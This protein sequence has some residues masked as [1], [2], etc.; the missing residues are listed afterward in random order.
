MTFT[1]EVDPIVQAVIKFLDGEELIIPEPAR[2]PWDR[3]SPAKE[4]S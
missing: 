1:P 4:H 2:A 3:L